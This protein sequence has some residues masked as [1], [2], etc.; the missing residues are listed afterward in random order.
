MEAQSQCSRG[1]CSEKKIMRHGCDSNQ[2]SMDIAIFDVI[3]KLKNSRLGN[4]GYCGQAHGNNSYNESV[5]IYVKRTSQ[6]ACQDNREEEMFVSRM[7]SHEKLRYEKWINELPNK[8]EFMLKVLQEMKRQ[9]VQNIYDEETFVRVVLEL[10]SKTQGKNNGGFVK[11][12]HITEYVSTD[13]ELSNSEQSFVQ[14]MMSCDEI[15]SED[16]MEELAIDK[17][18]FMAEIIR[19]MKMQGIKKICDK[20]SFLQ[21]YWEKKSK[22]LE[23]HQISV[24]KNEQFSSTEVCFV[25]RMMASEKINWI[26][27]L[28]SHKDREAFMFSLIRQMKKE[29]IKNI[30]DEEYFF[31]RI[32][33]E[34][35][36]LHQQAKYKQLQRNNGGGYQI[37][38]EEIITKYDN[39]GNYQRMNGYRASGHGGDFDGNMGADFYDGN[40]HGQALRIQQQQKKKIVGQPKYYNSRAGASGSNNLCGGAAEWYTNG[41]YF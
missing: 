39:N 22:K 9:G 40:F 15:T 11:G 7:M 16:W 38:R 36:R 18:A 8:K 28:S 34:M 23:S 37:I 4:G 12:P 30:C 14:E 27:E 31:K 17:E 32:H 19:D 10:K 35:K 21:R 25:K 41:R 13:F 2:E 6:T 29:G 5:E 1:N 33:Q 3:E 24:I 26:R 20:E